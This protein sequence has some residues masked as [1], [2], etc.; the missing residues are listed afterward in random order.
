MRAGILS[1]G[2]SPL[3]YYRGS[4]DAGESAW[5]DEAR[6]RPR[7]LAWEEALPVGLA[8]DGLHQ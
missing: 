1:G 8:G 7:R 2:D 3:E 4:W 5:S 6:D